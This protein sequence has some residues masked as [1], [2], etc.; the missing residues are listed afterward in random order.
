MKTE[1]QRIAEIFDRA[2]KESIDM[3]S[4]KFPAIVKEQGF[5]HVRTE[6]GGSFIIKDLQS[7]KYFRVKSMEEFKEIEKP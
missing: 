6:E 1:K 4:E 3:S 2:S 5:E 7:Q